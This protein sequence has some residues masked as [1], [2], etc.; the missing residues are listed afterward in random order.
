MKRILFHFENCL[1]LGIS[2]SICFCQRLK[3]RFTSSHWP[4]AV[5]PAPAGMGMFPWRGLLLPGAGRR[6]GQTD[7]SSL[8][9]SVLD[10]KATGP[11][12]MGLLCGGGH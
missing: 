1:N 7:T 8:K 10:A 2:M 5:S 9:Q 12:F 4:S 6:G 11:R 3:F